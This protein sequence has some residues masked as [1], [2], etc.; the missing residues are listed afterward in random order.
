VGLLHP[1]LQKKLNIDQDIWLF[2]LQLNLISTK[3]VPE[4]KVLSK[5]PEVRR[6]LAIV[7]ETTV[8]AGEVVDVASKAAGEHLMATVVFDQ[9][10]GAGVDDGK[11]SIGLGLTWQHH[12][13]TLNEDEVNT[14]IEDVLASLKQRFKASLR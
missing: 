12:E 7:V 11:H 1:Q 6:D 3:K 13:R 10:S 2:E 8:T 9:Y 4:F 5:F 14:L